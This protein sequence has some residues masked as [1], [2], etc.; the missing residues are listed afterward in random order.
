[1]ETITCLSQWA[2]Q[3]KLGD[4]KCAFLPD[5][6]LETTLRSTISHFNRGRGQLDGIHLHMS[7][8]WETRGV[9]VVC[10]SFNDYVE[11]K[12]DSVYARNW[13][14]Q[15]KEFF[16]EEFQKHISLGEKTP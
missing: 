4:I 12:R 10:V 11:H 3:F 7:Y 8:Y 6:C 14:K 1:M 13:K 5:G 15:A 16:D 9:C 2:R